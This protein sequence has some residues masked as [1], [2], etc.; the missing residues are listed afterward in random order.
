L[1]GYKL[2]DF[3]EPPCQLDYSCEKGFKKLYEEIECRLDGAYDKKA[4][5]VPEVF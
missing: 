4:F 2:R 5:C 1:N 3:V